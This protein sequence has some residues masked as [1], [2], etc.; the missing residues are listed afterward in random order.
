VNNWQSLKLTV[1]Q[2]EQHENNINKNQDTYSNHSL[3]TRNN[4]ISDDS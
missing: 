1:G 4:G 2:I 3:K